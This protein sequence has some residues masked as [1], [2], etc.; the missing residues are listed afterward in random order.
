MGTCLAD[1]LWSDVAVAD[2]ECAVYDRDQKPCKMDCCH[3]E[4]CNCLLPVPVSFFK[5][6]SAC[7]SRSWNLKVGVAAQGRP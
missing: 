6:G 5:Y 7:P 3:M 4:S 2:W 1:S